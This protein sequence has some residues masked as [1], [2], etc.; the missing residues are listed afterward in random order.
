[1]FRVMKTESHTHTQLARERAWWRLWQQQHV[2]FNAYALFRTWT[3]IIFNG[4]L[5][6]VV[7]L[8]LFIVVNPTGKYPVI[9]ISLFDMYEIMRNPVIWSIRWTNVC[10][11]HRRWNDIMLHLLI[12]RKRTIHLWSHPLYKL[13]CIMR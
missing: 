4:T 11:W 1:M 6:Y 13:C 7:L 3:C 8:D 9:N 2:S 10:T 5:Y 12:V